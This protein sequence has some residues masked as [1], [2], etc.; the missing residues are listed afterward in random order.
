MTYR[1]LLGRSITLMRICPAFLILGLVLA[2]SGAWSGA[3]L[4]LEWQSLF[5]FLG[6]IFWVW[7]Y[8]RAVA[9]VVAGTAQIARLGEPLSLGALWAAGA[10]GPG[11]CGGW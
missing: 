1:A 5:G 11:G 6:L 3:Y 8:P 9:A 10:P 4:P 7:L 2:F